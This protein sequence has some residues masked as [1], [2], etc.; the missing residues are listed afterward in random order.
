M[1]IRNSAKDVF[2]VLN[3]Y[4]LIN[5]CSAFINSIPDDPLI[6]M[7]HGIDSA[8]MIVS[9]GPE[10]VLASSFKTWSPVG[11]W[12]P[13][14]ASAEA[15]LGASSSHVNSHDH[16]MSL[17]SSHRPEESAIQSSA[18]TVNP[19]ESIIIQTLD[20]LKE[21]KL[22]HKEKAAAYAHL[23]EILRADPEVK[24]IFIKHATD[25]TRS[26]EVWEAQTLWN[27]ATTAKSNYD[28]IKSIEEVYGLK[29]PYQI[30]IRKFFDL[31]VNN[32]N[33][34]SDLRAAIDRYLARIPLSG[35]HPKAQA[36][37][38]IASRLKYS[39]SHEIQVPHHDTSPKDTPDHEEIEQKRLD[40]VKLAKTLNHEKNSKEAA[41]E[42]S[43][44]KELREQYV[45]VESQWAL[46]RK[47]VKTSEGMFGLVKQRFSNLNRANHLEVQEFREQM[48]RLLEKEI[49]RVK[50]WEPTQGWQDLPKG[51]QSTVIEEALH[52]INDPTISF[53]ERGMI[54]KQLSSFVD[55]NPE[56]VKEFN[57]ASKQK[58]NQGYLTTSLKGILIRELQNPHETQDTRINILLR[59]FIALN[60]GSADSINSLREDLERVLIDDEK[61][62]RGNEVDSDDMDFEHLITSEA[63]SSSSQ[64]TNLADQKLLSIDD[65]ILVHKMKKLLISEHYPLEKELANQAGLTSDNFIGKYTDLLKQSILK[66]FEPSKDENEASANIGAPLLS[67]RALHL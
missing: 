35:E 33:A 67:R 4:N 40:L 60:K 15:D 2:F 20:H 56:L 32:L 45:N 21:P 7:W 27:I 19:Y 55:Q 14:D 62:K 23:M 65:K 10:P 12:I 51:Q 34:V 16:E 50:A 39:T 9:S 47:K 18:T 49:E 36:L 1:L 54:Y 64:K 30:I 61:L 52:R 26:D 57:S 13:A 11:G 41:L 3:F 38:E 48:E 37:N 44:R 46:L 31:D 29:S 28:E 5:F 22:T 24:S 58:G 17:I 42:S 25:P 43:K 66:K 8:P 63:S 59:R 53:G 6:N